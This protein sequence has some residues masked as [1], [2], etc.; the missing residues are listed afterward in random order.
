M[1]VFKKIYSWDFWQAISGAYMGIFMIMH[2][3]THA[4]A[5]FGKESNETAYVTLRAIYQNINFEII[6]VISLIIHGYTGFKKWYSRYKLREL[7][8][9]KSQGK[10]FIK[11]IFND[12]RN[13]KKINRYMGWILLGIIIVHINGTRIEPIMYIGY[14]KSKLLDGSLMYVELSELGIFSKILIT[15]YMMYLPFGIYHTLYGMN[16]NVKTL[17]RIKFIDL[18][19]I[20][21]LWV[22]IIGIIFTIFV[23]MGYTGKIYDVNI[24]PKQRELVT[25]IAD[26]IRHMIS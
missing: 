25:P 20:I 19:S 4:T 11:E 3:F 16:L 8:K 21:W 7:M 15:T 14:N 13:P 1:S 2:V 6:F 9:H 24:S 22:F 17:M 23:I 10:S 26:H 12:I 5:I 18:Y